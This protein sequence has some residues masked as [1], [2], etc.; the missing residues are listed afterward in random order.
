MNKVVADFEL[1]FDNCVSY[2]RK[3]DALQGR[4]YIESAIT[5]SNH[6]TKILQEIIAAMPERASNT[7]RAIEQQKAERKAK[8]MEKRRTEARPTLITPTMTY[9]EVPPPLPVAPMLVAP[10]PITRTQSRTTTT[11]GYETQPYASPRPLTSRTTWHAVAQR[12]LEILKTRSFPHWCWTIFLTPIERLVEQPEYTQLVL[13]PISWQTIEGQLGSYDRASFIA[14]MRVMFDNCLAY[15]KLTENVP[16]HWIR[17]PC[18]FLYNEF[19]LLA[20]K[21]PPTAGAAEFKAVLEE[22]KLVRL[23]GYEPYFDFERNPLE[24]YT[25]YTIATR[26]PMGFLDTLHCR[27]TFEDWCGLMNE[28]FDAACRYH[29]NGRGSVF[30]HAE[31]KYLQKQFNAIADVARAVINRNGSAAEVKCEEVKEA[32][33]AGVKVFEVDKARMTSEESRKCKSILDEMMKYPLAKSFTQ[34]F[35][36]VPRANTFVRALRRDDP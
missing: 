25:N 22:L 36:R 31:A 16:I 34:C 30:I 7:I 6:V 2:W 8:Q 9:E 24:Y 11:Y 1:L 12:C 18:R 13:T 26:Q 17:D 23:A 32:P 3:Y 28:V 19:N 10:V 5:L 33:E 14:S 29:S 35:E 4:V 20:M 21:L 15:N 27:G